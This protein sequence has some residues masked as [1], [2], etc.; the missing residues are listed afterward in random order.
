MATPRIPI[1]VIPI[2]R[3]AASIIG[4]PLRGGIVVLMSTKGA[5]STW[6]ASSA[7]ADGDAASPLS[8][9]PPV[10]GAAAT[11]AP[12]PT[13]VPPTP[14]GAALPGHRASHFDSNLELM[15]LPYL[16]YCVCVRTASLT[17]VLPNYGA[18][19]AP[20]ALCR[21]RSGPSQSGCKYI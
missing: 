19:Q 1:V 14:A 2:P 21:A 5:F 8:W 10:G 18:T 13:P 16:I 15:I 9:P 6:G 11:A 12:S 17:G 20:A 7:S 3:C 4:L